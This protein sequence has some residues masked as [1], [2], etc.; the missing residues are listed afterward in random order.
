VHR[1]MRIRVPNE[2]RQRKSKKSFDIAGI[3]D[4][5][6]DDESGSPSDQQEE[7]CIVLCLDFICCLSLCEVSE[8]RVEIWMDVRIV[9]GSE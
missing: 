6:D 9:C 4:S 3:H 2:F 1:K 7:G 5:H 8:R